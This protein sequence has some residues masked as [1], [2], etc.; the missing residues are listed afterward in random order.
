MKCIAIDGANRKWIGTEKSGVFL[1]SEEGTEEI[2]H[3]TTENSP[4][5]SNNIIDIAINPE[6]GEVFIGTGEGLISYRSDA[7]EGES[8]QS[9]THVFPNPV[10]ESYNGPIAINGLV[11]DANIKI[12]DIDGNLVFEDFAKGG[13]AIW[14]GKN[15]NG[16][17]ASTGVYL[18]FSTDINGVE[19]TVSKIL[20]IH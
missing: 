17:R 8:A 18:V 10:R 3:F 2:L 12:T 6:N 16:E 11:T 9:E 19:K 1:L 13:Q 7:T 15:K 5:F 14:N 20:F 4:L